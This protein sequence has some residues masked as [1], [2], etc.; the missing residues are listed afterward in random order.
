VV[1]LNGKDHYLGR[2]GTK[3]SKVAYDGLIGEW[4]AGGRQLPDPEHGLSMNEV[5]LAYLH[6]ATDRYGKDSNELGCL[7]YALRI[8]KEVCGRE[9]ALDFGPKRLKGIRQQ[10]VAMR[11][12]RSYVNHQV[13][14]IRRAIRWAVAGEL[15]PGEVLHRLTAVEGLRYGELGTRESEPVKPVPE[16]F[17]E[18]VKPLVSLQVRAMIELQTLTAMRPGEVAIMRSKD[19]D[20]SGRVWVYRPQHHKTEHHG[21]ERVIYLGPRAQEVLKPWLR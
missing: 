20:M 13:Q 2:Y 1:T 12:C 19:L 15:I 11:W 6:H 9:L 16:A 3:Q 17:I 18:A 5:I 4:L 8:V 7:K 14:R 10:M 21:H